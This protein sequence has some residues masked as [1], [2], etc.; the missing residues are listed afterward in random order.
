MTAHLSEG[1]LERLF[2]VDFKDLDSLAAAEP[3]R[4]ALLRLDA[5]SLVVVEY[6]TVTSTLTISV[7]RDADVGETLVELLE[8]V[9][10]TPSSIEWL[11]KE[12]R[13]LANGKLSMS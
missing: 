8:E 11:A 10:F 1:D 7:P 12:V 2:P 13:V 4:A 3:S 6:G 9:P 5:G